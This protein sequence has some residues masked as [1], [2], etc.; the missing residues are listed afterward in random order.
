MQNTFASWLVTGGT[1]LYVVRDLLGHA[2][3]TQ[4]EPYAHLAPQHKAA[5]VASLNRGAASC[6]RWIG[7][8]RAN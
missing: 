2:G 8:E 7:R 6:R 3:I 1:G 5:T 4:T